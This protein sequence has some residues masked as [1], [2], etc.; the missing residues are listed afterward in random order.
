MKKLL[1][2]TNKNNGAFEED[3]QLIKFL[4]KD[5]DLI[6][7]HPLDCVSLLS[8]VEGVIIRNIWP[9]HEYAD[10]WENIRQKII[11]FGLPTYNSLLGN[12]DN[13]GKDYLLKLFQNNYQVIPSV[14]SLKDLS[15]L[16]NQEF[17][18]I[19]P[20]YGCDGSGA[21][22]YSKDELKGKDL[23][24]YI[25]Q[26]Y[27][28]FVS[29]PSFFFIDQNFSHAITTSNRLADTGIKIYNATNEDLIF[30]K[31]F[32]DWNK[33]S[34]GIQRIDTVRT[35]TSELLLTE[36][37]DLCPYLYID[38]ISVGHKQ[39]FL[40]NIRASVIKTLNP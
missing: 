21:G 3:Q 27:V 6:V 29:E 17:Y 39:F 1:F 9:T 40:N 32:V 5:F 34:N 11:D 22:K 19:K 7:S 31:V 16:G 35:K 15:L 33:L 4:S 30:A 14:D 24:D 10:Q 36:I 8:Q 37:E 28:E 18:W 12:G 26:P 38:D 13:K 2:L 20:K 25:I 23:S